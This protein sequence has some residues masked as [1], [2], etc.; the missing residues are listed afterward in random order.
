MIVNKVRAIVGRWAGGERERYAPYSLFALVLVVPAHVA[1]ARELTASDVLDIKSAAYRLIAPEERTLGLNAWW[2]E[3]APGAWTI[4][5]WSTV[6]PIE[7]RPG[8]CSMETHKLTRREGDANFRRLDGGVP[9]T[10]YWRKPNDTA[11]ESVDRDNLPDA[12]SV[13]PLVPTN[14]L[15]RIIDDADEL[16]RVAS[17][18]QCNEPVMARVFQNVSALKLRALTLVFRVGWG[19][20]YQAFFEW[21]RNSGPFIYFSLT[22]TTFDVKGNCFGNVDPMGPMPYLD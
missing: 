14:D 5:F 19:V 16:L 22:P 12:V 3:E 18:M 1:S 8:L 15:I 7:V 11:C 21:Q 4:E 20:V 6:R 9:S 13:W 2:G 10:A 17:E